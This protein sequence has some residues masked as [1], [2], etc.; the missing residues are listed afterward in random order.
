MVKYT[1]KQRV[2]GHNTYVKNLSQKLRKRMFRRKYSGTR[3][4]ASS[5]IFK[6]VK[7]VRSNGSFLDKNYSRQNGCA[8]QRKPS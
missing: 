8:N 6:L 3:V 5:M 7:E 1:H 2:F 4:P